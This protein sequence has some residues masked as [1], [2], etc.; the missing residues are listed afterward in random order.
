M[1][2]ELKLTGFGTLLVQPTN[3]KTRQ[4]IIDH[5]SPYIGENNARLDGGQTL[6]QGD[7]QEYIEFF[8]LTTQDINDLWAGW[9]VRKNKIDLWGYYHS[10]VGYCS[11]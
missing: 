1:Q 7:F 4:E 8:R 5:L 9:H 3:K 10:V 11:D 2:I 6:L